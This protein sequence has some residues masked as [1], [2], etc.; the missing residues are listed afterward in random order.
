MGLRGVGGGVLCWRY[1]AG[2]ITPCGAGRGQH[3]A[4]DSTERGKGWPGL[5]FWTRP[6]PS[7]LA[8]LHLHPFTVMNSNRGFAK[9]CESSSQLLNLR[10]HPADQRRTCE[11]TRAHPRPPVLHEPLPARR[12][13]PLGNLTI[14][15]F[16]SSSIALTSSAALGVSEL[17]GRTNNREEA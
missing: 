3:W 14:L 5:S 13:E 8:N 17:V 1:P 4:P 7:S 9:L 12:P 15:L 2:I 11:A 6:C 10:I 16:T